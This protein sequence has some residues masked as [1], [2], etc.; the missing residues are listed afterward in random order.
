MQYHLNGFVPGDPDIAPAGPARAVGENGLPSHV[1]VIIAGCGPAGLCLAAQLARYPNIST[2]IVEPK[3][4]PMEKGQADGISVRSME[5]FQTFGFA[6]KLSRE[7]VWINETTFWT[8]NPSDPSKIARVGRVKDVEEGISEMP[9]VLINQARI[10]DMFLDV[11]KNAPTRLE[12]DYNL[13][14]AD[15]DINPNGGD[16]PVTAHLN[17][18]MRIAAAGKRLCMQNTLSDV[19]ARA[20][21]C[22]AQ[23][24]ASCMG[25]PPIRHGA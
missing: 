21:R 10:H 7:S 5:M 14:I 22:A 3:S 25:M 1:D 23:S 9:H 2:M 17:A 8:P 4:G 19:T 13:K 11:M 6:E 12:P 16:Y 18:R 20:A 15:L 24:A